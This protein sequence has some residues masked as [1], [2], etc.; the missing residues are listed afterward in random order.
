V[1]I[2]DF[3]RKENCLASLASTEKDGALRELTDLLLSNKDIRD[4]DAIFE[5]IMDRERLGSTGIGDHVAIPHAKTNGIDTFVA[6]FGRSGEGVEYHSVDDKPVQ[7]IFMP[8]ATENATGIHLKAL[9]R[10]S[11]LLKSPSFREGISQAA[12]S[13][14]IY[15]VISDEDSKLA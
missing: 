13:D 8:L 4:S 3:L 6:A 2:V 9:A 15:L 12:T 5:A 7:W 11:R 10:I 14:E 1:R